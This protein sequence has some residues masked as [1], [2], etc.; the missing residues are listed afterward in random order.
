VWREKCSVWPYFPWGGDD[1]CFVFFFEQRVNCEKEKF[2]S[3]LGRNVNRWSNNPFPSLLST[4][5][6]KQLTQRT[7]F[8]FLAS[9]FASA[10]WI[11]LHS[12]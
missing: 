4:L 3:C 12:I 8:H 7:H 5:G 6:F 2:N 10:R 11:M 9:S 1:F